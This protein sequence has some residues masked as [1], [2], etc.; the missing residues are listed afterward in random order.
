MLF[1]SLDFSQYWDLHY[2][3]SEELLEFYSPQLQAI[4]IATDCFSRANTLLLEYFIHHKSLEIL[5]CRAETWLV[6]RH[7]LFM[8]ASKPGTPAASRHEGAAIIECS[9]RLTRCAV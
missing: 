3:E 1:L 9:L 6:A 8:G 5:P 2:R 7:L 4:D